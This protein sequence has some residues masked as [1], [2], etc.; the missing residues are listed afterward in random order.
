ME[1]EYLKALL[2]ITEA[3]DRLRV[4]VAEILNILRERM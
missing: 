3:I 1:E 2:D 4:A